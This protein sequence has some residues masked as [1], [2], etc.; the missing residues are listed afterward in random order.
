VKILLDSCVS[1]LVRD[2]LRARGHDAVWVR[3]WPRDPAILEIAH[4]EARVLITLDKDFGELAVVHHQ[5][6]SG[7]IRL[8]DQ[9]PSIHAEECD[10]ILREH[11]QELTAGA[12]VTVEIG[13]RRIRPPQ[14]T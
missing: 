13:R 12:I 3:D 8:V 11:G 2:E 4:R 6:H 14:E 5:A 10:E 9:P 7:I 1:F